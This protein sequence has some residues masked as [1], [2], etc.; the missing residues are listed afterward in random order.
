MGP[1]D[2]SERRQHDR[3]TA[4]ASIRLEPVSGE[5][6]QGSI[7]NFSAGGL[8][9]VTN[10]TAPVGE[11]L[12]VRIQ[13]NDG[14]PID[15]FF[16]R[17]SRA[18]RRGVAITFDRPNLELAQKLRRASQ[19]AGIGGQGG[20]AANLL[21][22]VRQQ[23]LEVLGQRFQRFVDD[24]RERLLE[25][26]EQSGSNNVQGLY[27]ESFTILRRNAERLTD[28]F[29]RAVEEHLDDFRELDFHVPGGANQELSLVDEHEFEMW[30]AESEIASSA[31]SRFYNQV[32]ALEA[33]L[34]VLRED[35]VDARNNP[36]GPRALAHHGAEAL[37]SLTLAAQPMDI[38]LRSFGRMVLMQLGAFYEEANKALIEGGVLP[39]L[40]RRIERKKAPP[41]PDTTGRPAPDTEPSEPP[42]RQAPAGAGSSPSPTT[43]PAA[44]PARAHPASTVIDLRE[45]LRQRGQ[46][47]GGRP[48][49]DSGSSR[50]IDM[51]ELQEALATLQHHRGDDPDYQRLEKRLQQA[52]Q[53][54]FKDEDQRELSR[55]HSDAVFLA[56]EL[57]AAI[58]ADLVAS[59]HGKQ[60]IKRLEV[61]LLRMLLQDDTMLEDPQ[62]PARQLMN[63]LGQVHYRGD[64]TLSSREME[65]LQTIDRVVDQ[66][67][68]S[69]A[70]SDQDLEDAS[71]E[72]ESLLKRQSR[73][74]ESNTRRVLEAAE[75]KE[76][77]TSA[78]DRVSHLIGDRFGGG[79]VPRILVDLLDSGLRDLMAL[80][81]LR[82]DR[83]AGEVDQSLDVLQRLAHRLQDGAT[84]LSE[85]E[86][87]LE[88]VQQRLERSGADPRSQ[89]EVL[90]HLRALLVG[91]ATDENVSL[92]PLEE[93]ESTADTDTEE[94]A[95]PAEPEANFWLGR[96]KLL[97]VGSWMLCPDMEGRVRPVK[98]AWVNEARD[99]YVFV[100]R[101]G[102]KAMEL[103]PD[104]LATRLR[105]DEASIADHR[106]EPLMDRSW[107]SIVQRMHDQIAHQ[108]THDEL[109]GLLNRKEFE[110]RV[111]LKVSESKLIESSHM[112]MLADIDQ[113]RVINT[114]A[115]HEAG[116]QLLRDVAR[117]LR[118]SL[119]EDAVIARIGA[120]EFGVLLPR[121]DTGRGHEVANRLRTAV[122][123]HKTGWMT[124]RLRVTVSV[125]VA[126]ISR[127]SLS[128]EEIMNR[129]E[130]A[131]DAAKEEGDRIRS[132]EIDDTEL[133]QRDRALQRVAT[134]EKAIDADRIQLVGH[135]IQP[136]CAPEEEAQHYEVLARIRDEDGREIPPDEFIAAAEAYGR[137]HFLDE[138]V[139][140][141][142]FGMVV[143]SGQASS[144]R[145]SIN[146][147]GRTFSR[148]Q[149]VRWMRDALER[150]AISPSRI[151]IEIT[152]TAAMSN[153][154]RCADVLR[155]LRYLGCQFSLDDF[156]TGLA[157]FGYLK[158]L[159]VDYL[160]IDGSF[161]R[162]ITSSASDYG[163]VRTINE[164][165]HLLGKRTVAEHVHQQQLIGSLEE[166][167]I[168]YVQGHAIQKPQ[169]LEDIL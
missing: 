102:H 139:V 97:D 1:G 18:D 9:V 25:A 93:D 43:R 11:R 114:T 115:G 40:E 41:R 63:H 68:R 169:P 79:T 109:T 70:L 101:D 7:G 85:D 17:V 57:L 46:T 76:R 135:L 111:R 58:T 123:R 47:V 162:E 155:E 2:D 133:N 39:K 74:R 147:S 119:P 129:L 152:E 8:Y 110:R 83:D 27:F 24:V 33:R 96:A 150:H 87:L 78:R 69:E 22:Q 62:H 82:E 35:R 131:C 98:L 53:E 130:V 121:C 20:N 105:T 138:A 44:G 28:T 86:A 14:T 73:R 144:T 51:S 125:G 122:G 140:E 61:P 160:K 72:I 55:Q 118:E 159:P 104:E 107:Q 106:D 148:P 50:E 157:S 81:V 132:F 15:P 124:R 167:G 154:S 134:L 26:A 95:P 143:D 12:T 31:E 112:L 128:V 16:A 146:I 168:D 37:R 153:L 10:A 89:R 141:K 145:L 4:A 164:I 49:A 45:I 21:G 166:M 64:A 88:E 137:I 92:P 103:T 65:T 117:L 94:E 13:L 6:L 23:A 19:P 151:C 136:L 66:L 3:E 156:G 71:A 52:L 126:G 5:P 38:A 100:D 99:H 108:A 142:T 54:R 67:A 149:F 75:G 113:F 48:S 42:M 80:E 30:L 32:H 56:D 163:L 90:D 60:W 84:D 120:D 77:L 116:D 165:A 127:D 36:L 34:S 29:R 161:I 91:E 158:H 59:E